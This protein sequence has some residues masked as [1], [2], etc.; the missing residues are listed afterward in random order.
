LDGASILCGG[1]AIPGAI[2]IGISSTVASCVAWGLAP[3]A[4]RVF[5]CIS[6]LVLIPIDGDVLT[7]Q[8]FGRAAKYLQTGLDIDTSLISWALS[9]A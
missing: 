4:S 3:N 5:G 6:G 7:P 1:C 8:S 9:K 2:A